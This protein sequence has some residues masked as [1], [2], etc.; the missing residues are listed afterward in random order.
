MQQAHR[1]YYW[2][3]HNH[4]IMYIFLTI[5]F[6][7]FGYGVF[8]KIMLWREMK[9]ADERFTDIFRRAFKMIVDVLFQGR[10]RKKML[11]GVFHSMIFWSFLFLMLTT[12]ILTVQIDFAEPFLKL[13]FFK[14]SIYLVVSFFADI[15]GG[16]FISGLLVAVVRR[17]IL[18][19]KTLPTDWQ[20]AY[21]LGLLLFIGIGGFVLEGLRIRFAGD[22]WAMYSP[23]GLAVSKALVF[24]KGVVPVLYPMIWWTHAGA[25]F[26]LIASLPYTKFI[27]FLLI[28]AN[29]MFSNM[30]P[31]GTLDREDLEELFARDDVDEFR[32]G[33]ADATDLTW[34][35]AMDLD[36]CIECGRCEENCP[37]AQ[38]GYPLVPREFIKSLKTATYKY[39]EAI[40][41]GAA[42]KKEG[43]AP[44]KIELAPFI[45]DTIKEEH[46][47]L[48]RT[49]R[50]CTESCPAMIEHVDQIVDV[51]RAQVMMAGELPTDAKNALKAMETRGNPFGP[52]QDRLGWI[53]GD[54]PEILSET[55]ETDVLFWLGCVANY[56]QAKQHIA[57]NMFA[58]MR[59]SGIRFAMLGDEETCC[60]DPARCLGDENVFQSIAKGQVE[61]LKQYKFNKIVTICPHCAATLKN[62]FPQFGGKF[63]VVHHTKFIADLVKAGKIRLSESVSGKVT[64]HD[65]CYLGRYAGVF[66]EPRSLVKSMK[67]VNFVETKN[68]G[69]TSFCC[70]AGGGNYYMDMDLDVPG[71]ER[72]N[73]RRAKELVNTGADTIAVACPYCMQMLEDA[74]KLIEMDEKVKMKDISTLVVEAMGL[75][76]GEPKPAVIHAESNIAQEAKVE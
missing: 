14:G 22:A 2:H 63:E 53:K 13:D 51:R 33:H 34:K 5:S 60:G 38:C 19:P 7:V 52:Q 55:G 4:W 71:D 30:K 44:G 41:K 9:P 42:G 61:V 76:V 39:Y 47:W 35:N 40:E 58:I 31:K 20:N 8:R 59:H 75:H 66:D 72:L 65:P 24:P 43:E 74:V 68:H 3:V 46:I 70:G 29:Y 12:A 57:N 25:T 37:V 69:E 23:L 62:E 50:A 48:C 73:V 1:E 10:I 45:G 26:A 49:C 17:Y 67:G 15:A 32:L 64:Y 27:H 28:P 18:K 6:A 54:R 36:A 21:M 11:P 16:I 56:D